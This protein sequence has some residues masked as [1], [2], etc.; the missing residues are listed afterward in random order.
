M[1]STYN[2]L[3]S[4]IA[5]LENVGSSWGNDVGAIE[6][7]QGNPVQYQSKQAGLDALQTQL[8]YDASGASKIYSP[9]M[10]LQDFETTYTGGNTQA[11]NTFSEMLGVPSSTTLA[12]LSD[13]NLYPMPAIGGQPGMTIPGSDTSIDI[14]TPQGTVTLT[15]P[16]GSKTADASGGFGLT[17]IGANVVGI[18]LGLVLIAGAVFSFDQ[19]RDLTKSTLKGVAAA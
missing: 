5:K 17:S 7:A 19:I 14:N 18:I 13:Q 16:N 15:G 10:T 8:Q 11:G 9:D 12:Q 3:A 4:M 1:G 2:T 6:D